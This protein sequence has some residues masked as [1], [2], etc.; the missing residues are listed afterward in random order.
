M[1]NKSHIQVLLKDNIVI[2][3]LVFPT[4]DPIKIFNTLS[5]FDYDQII[6]LRKKEV[7]LEG[8][9]AFWDGKKFIAKP[10]P[11]WVLNSDSLWEAPIPAPE[12]NYYW[13]EATKTWKQQTKGLREDNE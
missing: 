5:Q 10:F 1:E 9:G 11:S 8:F 6:D 7:V 12:G 4:N 3:E 13:H 2:A